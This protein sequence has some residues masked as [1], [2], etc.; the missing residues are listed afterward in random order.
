MLLI[1]ELRRI[2]IYAS[3]LDFVAPWSARYVVAYVQIF[4]P[5]LEVKNLTVRIETLKGSLS[6]VDNISFSLTE[7]EVLG[8]VGESGCGKSMAS[9]ALLD[10]LPPFSS[11]EAQQLS[12]LN[13]DLLHASHREKRNL[14]G[15]DITMIFQDPMTSLNPSFTIGF[16][17]RESIMRAEHNKKKGWRKRAIELLKHVGIS[18][19]HERLDS[20]PHELSGGMCQRI[21]IAMAI[22]TRPQLLIADEPTT[23]LDVTIQAQILKLLQSL[24]KE[25]GMAMI[26]I[27]HN[28]GLLAHMA[29]RVMVM[30]AGQIMEMGKTEDIILRP[31][32]PYTQAL[33]AA[34]PENYSNTKHRTELPSIPGL[35]PDLAHRPTGCQ[36]HPRCKEKFDRCE[37]ELPELKE[38]NKRKIACHLYDPPSTKLT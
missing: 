8:I 7:G 2:V 5:L 38:H 21:M 30:Y 35:V 33:L 1:S 17:L 12:F 34:L 32:H 26:L 37:K 29:N 14:R 15:K 16:Q 25:F 3:F 22:A 28:I 36:F 10:L 18:E 27:S 13:R 31:E 9:Y 19:A 11:L 20:Y 24:Q 4:M 6:A 23:A